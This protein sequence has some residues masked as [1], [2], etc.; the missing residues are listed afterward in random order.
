MSEIVDDVQAVLGAD[1]VTEILPG[2]VVVHDDHRWMEDW[3]APRFSSWVR[4]QGEATASWFAGH[5]AHEDVLAEVRELVGLAEELTN[6]QS[7]GEYLFFLA[8]SAHDTAPRLFCVADGGHTAWLVVD[9]QRLD[10]GLGAMVSA[11]SHVSIDWFTP[12][13]DGERIALGLSVDGSEEATLVVVGRDGRPVDGLCLSRAYPMRLNR[14]NVGGVSWSPDGK[15]LAYLRLSDLGEESETARYQHASACLRRLDDPHHEIV[16]MRS[17]LHQDIDLAADDLPMV[18]LVAGGRAVLTVAHASTRERSVYVCDDIGRTDPAVLAWRRLAGPED[19]VHAWCVVAD[20]WYAGHA[21]D[22]GWVV[23]WRD[24]S[25]M[26]AP[27]VLREEEGSTLEDLVAVGSAVLVRALVDGG[28]ALVALH[29]DHPGRG[30]VRLDLPER[31]GVAA[32]SPVTATTPAADILVTGWVSAPRVLRFDLVTGESEARWPVQAPDLAEDVECRLDHARG[33]DGTSIPIT[34]IGSASGGGPVPVWLTAYG[35]FGIT[36]RPV[37]T[38]LFLAWVRRGGVVVVAHVRGG[39]DCGDAWYRAGHR[40]HKERTVEDLLDV[41][42]HLVRSGI[43]TRALTVAEGTS[44]G[45]LTVGGAMVRAPERFGAV[46]LRV[47]LTNTLRLEMHDNGPPNIPEYGT[48]TTVDGARAL[49]T[50]DIYHRVEPHV[51]YP[52]VLLTVGLRDPRVLPWQPAKLAAR[53]QENGGIAL[54]RVEELGGHGVGAAT[55]QNVAES[56]DRLCFAL[57]HLGLIRKDSH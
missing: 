26:G 25:A 41:A 38:P 37:F 48:V 33:S 34:V 4:E 22:Q 40:E 11:R 50:S 51:R 14:A 3:R 27:Q 10:V 1:R 17:G 36:L 47:S 21:R 16:L 52:P 49:L 28:A 42:D 31:A 7:G 2:A 35:F 54:L 13:P 39:G 32:V 56:A 29:P 55:S 53:L 19:R 30:P 46:V 8:R 18:H 44:A 45:G 23:T 24:L 12:S 20:H 43:T 15:A 9:P 6:P 5:A 57:A